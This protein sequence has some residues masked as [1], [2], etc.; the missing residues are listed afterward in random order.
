MPFE[1][2]LTESQSLYPGLL[3]DLG[4][5]SKYTQLISLGGI[6]RTRTTRK[7]RNKKQNKI[8]K[9]NKNKKQNKIK[10]QNKNKKT[11]RKQFI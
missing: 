1:S 8:K 9:Q 7:I 3:T 10:K 4:Q 6:K 2:F 11:N 5:R